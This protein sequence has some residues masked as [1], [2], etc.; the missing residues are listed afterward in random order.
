M[1]QIFIAILAISVVS[2]CATM[3]ADTEKSIAVYENYIDNNKL[4]ALKSITSFRFHDWRGLDD[5]HLIISTSF[6]KPYLI[7]LKRTCTDL[8]SAHAIGVD[9]K[10]STLN[11][12]FDSIYVLKGPKKRCFIESIHRLNREQADEITGLR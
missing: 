9:N 7:T 6:S 11:A 3:E 2:G 8:S 12:G 4:E 5:E 10:G 1:K